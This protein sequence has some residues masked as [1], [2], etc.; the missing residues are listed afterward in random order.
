MLLYVGKILLTSVLVVAISELVKRNVLAGAVLA[1]VPLVS[2]LSLIWLYWDTRDAEIVSRFSMSVFWM[3]LP[4]LS[5]FLVLS[6]LL[7]KGFA[8]APALL[9]SLS[10]MIAVYFAMLRI[11]ELMGYKA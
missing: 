1:S 9:S 7:R 11:M 3:V 8:F 2:V 10:L 5:L 4:S 6:F